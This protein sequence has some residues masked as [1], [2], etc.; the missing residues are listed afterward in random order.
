MLEIH[1]RNVWL[2]LNK[3]CPDPIKY[4]SED[5]IKTLSGGLRS[6][7]A[8]SVKQLNVMDAIKFTL[9]EGSYSSL[10]KNNKFVRTKTK[11]FSTNNLD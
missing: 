4:H 3:L 5:L 9:Q 7:R 6:E 8:C 11:H 1:S 2:S 10:E